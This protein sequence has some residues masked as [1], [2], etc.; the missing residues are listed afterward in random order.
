MFVNYWHVGIFVS[1]QGIVDSTASASLDAGS[2][3]IYIPWSAYAKLKVTLKAPAEGWM[4]IH[5]AFLLKH[6]SP[7]QLL[8]VVYQYW[9]FL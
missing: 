1:V 7:S 4:I 5:I 9:L 3:I 2:S 6:K 8:A